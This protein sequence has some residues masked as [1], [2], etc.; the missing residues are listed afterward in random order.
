MRWV[1]SFRVAMSLF[2]AIQIGGSTLQAMQIGF[3]VVGNNIAN[4]NTPGYV[5]EEAIFAPAPVQRIG[6][7]VLGLGVTVESIQQKVDKFVQARLV[8]A[9]GDTANAEVQEKTYQ[10]MET[11]LN[12]LSG[13]V[14]L[15]S[16]M[17]DFFNSIQEVM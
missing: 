6:G 8:G 7:L 1:L 3:Q 11:V 5:R 9:Q 10:E 2:G 4:A 17:N 14:D 12:A 15:N 16:S 13:S